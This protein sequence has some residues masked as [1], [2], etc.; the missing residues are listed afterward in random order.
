MPIIGGDQGKAGE[1]KGQRPK[2]R[3]PLDSLAFAF[4]SH[5][6]VGDDNWDD[7]VDISRGDHGDYNYDDDGDHNDDDNDVAMAMVTMITLFFSQARSSR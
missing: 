5:D 1:S 2:G 4:Y 7:N 6:E 3:W